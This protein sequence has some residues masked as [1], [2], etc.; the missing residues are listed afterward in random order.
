M[1]TSSKYFSLYPY[2]RRNMHREDTVFSEL[3]LNRFALQNIN[4]FLQLH[5]TVISSMN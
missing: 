5:K 2:F 3:Y 1:T 4:L